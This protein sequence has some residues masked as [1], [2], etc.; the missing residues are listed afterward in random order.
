MLNDRET[1]AEIILT[2]RYPPASLVEIADLHTEMKEI[3]QLESFFKPSEPNLIKSPV[4]NTHSTPRT[5]R[6]LWPVWGDVKPG[7]PIDVWL[8]RGDVIGPAPGMWR[9]KPYFITST[10]NCPPLT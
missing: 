5:F 1:T 8:A 2:G 3:N 6:A 4:G 9:F 7:P 10:C